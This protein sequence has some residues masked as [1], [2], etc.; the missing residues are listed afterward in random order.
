MG[1]GFDADARAELLDKLVPMLDPSVRTGF[2]GMGKAPLVVGRD[3]HEVQESARRIGGARGEFGAEGLQQRIG[4]AGE[5]V[6]AET[7]A[8]FEKRGRIDHGVK[9][10]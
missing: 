7:A 4:D 5:E 2:F 1:A 9:R 8:V 10:V 6:D 3:D